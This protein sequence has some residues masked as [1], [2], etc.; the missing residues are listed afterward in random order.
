MTLSWSDRPPSGRVGMGRLPPTPGSRP[1]SPV[2]FAAAWSAGRD[3]RRGLAGVC[4]GPTEEV[5]VSEGGTTQILTHTEL[6]KTH[7]SSAER[8]QEWERSHPGGV[9]TLAS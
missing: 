6:G 4:P 9:V 7:Q 3:E 2:A 8:R 5:A 1:E